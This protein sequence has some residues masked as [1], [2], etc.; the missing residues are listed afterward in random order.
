[1]LLSFCLLF[2]LSF[3][4]STYYL[5]VQICDGGNTIWVVEVVVVEIAVVAVVIVR[6]VLAIPRSRPS[7]SGCGKL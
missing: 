5:C 2:D 3:S 4:Y 7:V 1:M 6:V